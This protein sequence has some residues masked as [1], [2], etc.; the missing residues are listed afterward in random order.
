[1]SS[2]PLSS[3]VLPRASLS[4]LTRAGYT[5]VQELRITSAESL[6]E[7]L[8]IPVLD[9]E[10]ILS[11]AQRPLTQTQTMPLTQ[12]AA[13]MAS[14]TQ[15]LSTRSSAVDS[16]LSGGLSQGHIL[17]VSG[18]PGS[19]KETVA[20]NVAISFVEAGHEVMFI[21]C[22]NMTSPAKLDRALQTSQNLPPNYTRLV[23]HLSMQSLP[24]LMVWLHNLP[25]LLDSYND[26]ALLVLNSMSFPFQ[27]VHSIPAKTALLEKIKQTFT[28]LTARNLTIVITSQ[29]STKILN[30]DGSS[31]SFDTGAKGI[32]VPQ[33]GPSYLPPGKTHRIIFAAEG[34]RS[35]FI[36]LIS[37]PKHEKGAGAGL[38]PSIPY[39]VTR[40]G[41]I[42]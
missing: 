21:D 2:R 18:T 35:G 32:M 28:R 22:Q 3:L 34:Q 24:E 4:K 11:L 41:Q 13:S 30:A 33:L 31:G 10:A 19:P 36:K 12:S 20:I 9:A 37:S 6:A 40:E 39:E 16:I 8:Q 38:S 29:L 5:T 23:Y 27:G 7:S 1:M 17:E 15:K 14:N 25:S 26:V 42:R